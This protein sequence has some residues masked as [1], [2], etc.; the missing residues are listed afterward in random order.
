MSA[1]PKEIEKLLV[2][3][4]AD[5][6]RAA[7]GQAATVDSENRPHV[8]TVH[9]YY[10]KATGSTAFACHMKSRKW[11]EVGEKPFLAGCYHD[12]KLLVQLR[13]E[14]PARHGGPEHAELLARV[15]SGIRPAVRAAYWA[16]SGRPEA[17]VKEVCP[18]IGLILCQPAFWDVFVMHPEDYCKGHRT[19]YRRQGELWA[20]RRLSLLHGGTP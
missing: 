14:G 3:S 19:L 6:K 7:Y 5:P 8:R 16:D 9:F 1:C 15:W 10:D 12:V 4:M 2:E 20:P 11:L 18:T 17:D 13:W